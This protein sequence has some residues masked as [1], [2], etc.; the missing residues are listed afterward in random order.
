MNQETRNER[1]SASV[2]LPGTCGEL[3]QGTLDG[4]PCLVSCPI[5]RYSVAEVGLWSEPY[6]DTPYDAPKAAA[7]LQA[8]LSYLEQPAPGGRLSLISDL[9]RGRGYA[10]STADVGAALF[11]LGEA[12]D[13][14]LTSAEVA[15]L[16]V[17]VE[18][19]D[20][21]VYPGL[22]MFDHRQGSFHRDLG[23][24]PPLAVIV[25]DSGGKVDTLDFNQR[26]YVEALR[27]L[28]PQ[29]REAFELLRNGLAHNDWG[30]IGEAATL[31]ARVH[32]AILPHPLLGR[33][34]SLAQEVAALGVC[35]AHSG[36]ILGVL[37]DPGRID[38]QAATAF[39]RHS[40]GCEAAVS[41]YRL[42]GGGPR[43]EDEIEC[44]RIPGR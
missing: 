35:R 8:G 29:H 27:K 6:W 10:S 21:T 9:P 34:L 40:F 24:A 14:P 5:D 3:V 1:I 2:A 11:A 13:R 18:P 32:Q 22:A 23:P 41:P 31:S 37:L 26:D 33:V 28:A 19:S 38:V 20:S 39:L 44:R 17:S 12:L 16:A 30:S 25:L 15:Q 36:T 4:V 42:V 43:K 7:A